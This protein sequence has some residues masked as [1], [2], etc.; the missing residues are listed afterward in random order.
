MLKKFKKDARLQM[1]S[2]L[3]DESAAAESGVAGSIQNFKKKLNGILEV[4]EERD[5]Q[6]PGSV[7][8]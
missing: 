5:H 4:K 3:N 2:S 6:E 7:L 1:S 8:K